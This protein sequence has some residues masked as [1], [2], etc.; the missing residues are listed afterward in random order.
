MHA[1]IT[2]TNNR[3]VA[4]FDVLLDR[5]ADHHSARQIS[6]RRV[7][8][9]RAPTRHFGLAVRSPHLA[10]VE[11]QAARARDTG[12]AGSRVAL[13]GTTTASRRFEVT[14]IKE[15][16]ATLRKVADPGRE[17]VLSPGGRG[18]GGRPKTGRLDA[19]VVIADFGWNLFCPVAAPSC[20]GVSRGS[21]TNLR[22]HVGDQGRE[23]NHHVPWKP[24]SLTPQRRGKVDCDSTSNS[25]PLQLSGARE[26]WKVRQHTKSD[27]AETLPAQHSR[28]AM[29][30]RRLLRAAKEL[31]EPARLGAHRDPSTE[32]EYLRLGGAAAG[33]DVP[34]AR[35]PDEQR[36][37]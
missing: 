20:G 2:P 37:M 10:R 5:V 19:D 22:F 32:K 26:D 13:T 24:S 28:L 16:T 18:R 31:A 6:D 7:E 33:A 9:L 23:E 14:A 17:S 1:P 35:D 25:A 4:N 34:R 3:S 29:I 27:D 8:R 21:A 12:S 36:Q 30:G 11:R 15:E